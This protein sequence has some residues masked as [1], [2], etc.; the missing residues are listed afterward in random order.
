VVSVLPPFSLIQNTCTSTLAAGGS[1]STG[2]I[3]TPTANGAVNGVLNVS[4]SAF[5]TAAVAILSGTGGAAGSVRLQ[6]TTLN[7]STVGVGDSSAAQTVTITNNG[8]ETL[9]ALA[10]SISNGFQLGSTTC[11]TSLAVGSSCT[12]QVMF[13]PT[14]AGHKTG[15]LTVASP[16]LAASV[17]LPLTGT[18]FDFTV[19]PSG[20][21]SQT[22]ASGQSAS[23]SLSLATIGGASGTFTFSCGSLPANSSCAFNPPSELVSADATGSVSVKITTGLAS[24]SAQNK[25]ALPGPFVLSSLSVALSIFLL[26]FTI[27]RRRQGMLLLAILIL[28]SFGLASCAGA[29]GGGS[30]GP[31]SNPANGTTPAGTYPVVVTATANGLSHKTTLSLT[32]D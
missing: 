20:Q 10:I 6:P 27:R 11:T 5:V 26:P 19:S 28:S 32:V 24:T 1:C 9:T 17:Q 23:F 22:V 7:F 18:G 15:S 13:T 4:S 16:S 14:T 8:V 3:F 2:V 29:G 30:G 12:A 21:A 25:N 31:P